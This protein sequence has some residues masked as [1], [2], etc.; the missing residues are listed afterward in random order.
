MKASLTHGIDFER[1]GK[2]ASS[3]T[4]KWQDG[5]VGFGEHLDVIEHVPPGFFS[6]CR[7]A[8]EK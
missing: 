6:G 7:V 2:T 8:L 4:L 5:A 1:L 3:A